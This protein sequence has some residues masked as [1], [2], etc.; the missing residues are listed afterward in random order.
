VYARFRDASGQPFGPV[1]DDIIY[2]PGPPQVTGV[3]I[4]AQTGEGISAMEGQDVIVRVTASDDN[5]GVA[6]VQLSNDRD[7]GVFSEFVVNGGTTGVPWT[8]PP[9][10]EVYARVVDR[11]GNLSLVSSGKATENSRVYLPII[12]KNR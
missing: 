9:S 1:Q 11:A 6:K 12:V 7:F 5:S 3:E 4:L 2:D 8:L 10:G